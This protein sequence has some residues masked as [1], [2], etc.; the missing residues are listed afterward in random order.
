MRTFKKLTKQKAKLFILIIL[1]QSCTIYKG[2]FVGLDQAVQNET[3]V[4]I[5]TNTKE[6]LKFKK[7]VFE[8]GNYFGVDKLKGEIA[9]IPLTQKDIKSIQEKNKSSST[10]AIIVG[11]FF[12]LFIV[13][14]VVGSIVYGL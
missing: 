14:A 12:G 1:L 3:N 7:I 11:S 9:K 10:I 4:K 5:K 13:Y 8:N 6:K 2:A